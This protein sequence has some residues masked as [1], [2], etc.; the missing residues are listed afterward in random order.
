MGATDM[1]GSG[2]RPLYHHKKQHHGEGDKRQEN[3]GIAADEPEKFGEASRLFENAF[4][5]V[6]ID[7]HAATHRQGVV[8]F[9]LCVRA[10]DFGGGV[11]VGRVVHAGEGLRAQ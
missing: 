9:E 11:A 5:D 4:G 6:N 10:L 1:P 3:C 8:G 2:S 7:R